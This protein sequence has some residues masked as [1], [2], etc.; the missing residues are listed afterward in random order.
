MQRK[1]CCC[2]A[3]A[4]GAAWFAEPNRQYRR[5][6][7]STRGQFMLALERNGGVPSGSH[8]RIEFLSTR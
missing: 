6:A 2:L 8:N 7:R 3:R 4:S 5:N 1:G